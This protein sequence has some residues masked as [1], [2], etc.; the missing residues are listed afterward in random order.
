MLSSRRRG[1]GMVRWRGALLRVPAMARTTYF[2]A[3]PFIRA[4]DGNL[5]AVEAVDAP[6]AAVAR[7]R[8]LVMSNSGE[9]IGAVAFS[10]TGDPQLG[11]FDEAV[12]LAR[13]GVTPDD[14]EILSR[15]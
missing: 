7:H 10:R 6:N 13:Y 2:V 5:I 8:A 4:A 12:V 15:S 14:L 3:V 11:E 1:A 9:N